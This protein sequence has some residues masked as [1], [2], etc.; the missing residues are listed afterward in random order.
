MG[1]KT[2][3]IT[4][5][6]LQPYYYFQVKNSSGGINLTGATL[7]VTMRNL[8][9]GVRKINRVTDRHNLTS[10]TAGVGQI[11]WQTGDTDIL[12]MYALEIEITPFGAGKFTVP[13]TERALVEVVASQ[14]NQ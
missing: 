13:K 6:D 14:D 9:T 2:L 1:L 8:T 12:G 7:R 3:Q 11:E 10:I 5:H 4:Q